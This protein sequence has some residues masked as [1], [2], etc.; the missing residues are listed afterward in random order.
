MNKTELKNNKAKGRFEDLT[1]KTING[2][3]VLRLER[4]IEN[5]GKNRKEY[6]W[7]CKCKRCGNEI[8]LRSSNI[9][10][11]KN[12]YCGCL[13]KNNIKLQLDKGIEYR[14]NNILKEGTRLD[15]ISNKLSKANTTGV[16]GVTFD[17]QTNKYRATIEFKG[18]KYDL[19]RYATLDKAKEIRQKAE[20]KFYKPI[21]EKY[22]Y[23]KYP[24]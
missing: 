2:L 3:E 4:V 24:K 5:Q 16:R 15:N 17:K 18:Q 11:R 13:S 20:E 6:S 14:K 12:Q 9:K 8:V 10:R 22:N 19:G 21:L 23:K 1:G 7:K